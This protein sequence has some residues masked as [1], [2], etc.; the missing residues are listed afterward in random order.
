MGTKQWLEC[1]VYY[2]FRS[3]CK[4]SVVAKRPIGD[5]FHEYYKVA[6][7]YPQTIFPE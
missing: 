7:V 2:H 4:S 5:D 6:S 3:G 1:N